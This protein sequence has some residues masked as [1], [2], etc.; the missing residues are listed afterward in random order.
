M[1]SRLHPSPTRAARWR[2]L[3]W[4][5]STISPPTTPVRSLSTMTSPKAEHSRVK[6]RLRLGI[7]GVSALSFG[8]GIMLGRRESAVNCSQPPDA[9]IHYGGP[10]EL[11]AVQAA[12]KNA[13]HDR[14][15]LVSTDASDVD[16]HA[17]WFTAREGVIP[18][19]VIVYPEST[20]DVVNI[21]E[22]AKKHRVPVVPYSGGTSME[23]HTTGTMHG[24]I[25]VDMS[26][27]NKIIE[28]HEA[29]SDVVVQPGL[30]WM[31]LND[32]L[33]E[34][35]IPLFFPLDPGPD[36]TLGGMFSTG[37]SG[38]NAVRYGTARAEWFL[39]ATIALPSGEVIKTRRRSRKSSAGWD[40]TK[41]FIGA[42]GTLGIVTELTVRLA[43]VLPTG[44]GIVS[45]PNVRK[46]C[47]AVNELLSRG[48]GMQCIELLD[49][50]Q[51]RA[52]N[53]Y[54]ASSDKYAIADHLFL[55]LQGATL[56]AV[57]ESEALAREITAKHGGENWISARG[58]E[59]QSMWDDRKI[60]PYA[61][62][63]LYGTPGAKAWATDVCVPISKLPQLVEEVREDMDKAGVFGTI[64]GH[65][66]D[67]NFHA[68]IFYSTPEEEKAAREVVHRM[69]KRALALDGTCTGEHGVGIGK[70]EYLVE[71]L[72]PGTVRLLK[73]VKRTLDPLGIMNPG[74]SLR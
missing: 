11:K 57:A 6:S 25:C 8:A 73:T 70:R 47:D 32:E 55:K 23:G 18:H 5:E 13:F 33:N 21:V 56:G 71:E 34:K 36:A 3:P 51:M 2:T 69:V 61:S 53:N 22:L 50:Y 30:G 72:G 60:A 28:I 42:E 58:D 38:T 64:L 68:G 44:V 49:A 19:N 66:G 54:H 40:V 7:A 26:Q 17:T 24:S 65:A 52:L 62:A 20:E 9:R 67:G 45:F 16:V 29:D 4:A 10:H 59:A 35:G 63:K 39:N 43:P 37:C 41:L 15:Q 31:A 74:K 1:L 48:V 27:M 46:A 14:P 12:L